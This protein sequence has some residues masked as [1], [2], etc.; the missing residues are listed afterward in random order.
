VL[1]S[2]SAPVRIVLFVDLKCPACRSF[3]R[4]AL[5]TVVQRLVRP[6]RAAVELHLVNIIDPNV[7]TTD[8]ARLR[9]TALNLTSRGG[10]WSFAR[11]VLRRQGDEAREWA[12]PE[13]IRALGRAAGVS[14]RAATMRSSR[15]SRRAAR[16]DD[17]LFSRLDGD[18][19]PFVVVRR[20]DG[21]RASTVTDLSSDGVERAVERA[22]RRGNP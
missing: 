5:G 6:G 19:T 2:G 3:E 4:R 15:A 7:G 12:T 22:E 17:R 18:G 9:T 8:G 21:G 1:G 20:R 13:R 16:A 11:T 14:V 10:L